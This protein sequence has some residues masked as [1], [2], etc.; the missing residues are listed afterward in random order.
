[1]RKIVC[2]L[3]ASLLLSTV[4]CAHS[5]PAA[6]LPDP[7]IPHR[8]AEEA[9]VVVWVRLANGSLVKAPVRLLPGWWIAGPPVVEPM[10]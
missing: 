3:S 6:A 5:R 4:S 10:P 8:V 2:A 1:M 9:E 7:T